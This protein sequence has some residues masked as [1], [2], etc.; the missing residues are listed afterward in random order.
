MSQAALDH[1]ADCFK[2][3]YLYFG[4][5]Q[6]SLGPIIE[7]LVPK[8]EPKEVE[9]YAEFET[10]TKDTAFSEERCAII[11]LFVCIVPFNSNHDIHILNKFFIHWNNFGEKFAVKTP[12]KKGFCFES[13]V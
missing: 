9:D 8:N 12:E 7:V 11:Y 1:L 13:G 5:L 2:A 4:S 6:T 10:T 3:S